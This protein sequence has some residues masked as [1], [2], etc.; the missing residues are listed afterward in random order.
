M[1]SFFI[2]IVF[3]S[4][5]YASFP[6]LSS[7]SQTT[8]RAGQRLAYRVPAPRDGTYRVSADK[9]AL[10]YRIAAGNISRAARGA[11]PRDVSRLLREVM[12][13]PAAKVMCSAVDGT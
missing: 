13:L 2:H 12:L 8:Y 5:I 3:L 4:D 6:Y 11:I 7:S 10:T 1:S 9:S